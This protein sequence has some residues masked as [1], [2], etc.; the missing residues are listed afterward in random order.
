MVAQIC[1]WVHHHAGTTGVTIP[2]RKLHLLKNRL[3]VQIKFPCMILMLKVHRNILGP[4]R[5][6]SVFRTTQHSPIYAHGGD[7]VV[8]DVG[9]GG[10]N[11][12]ILCINSALPQ[13]LV[14]IRPKNFN[15][16]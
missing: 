15:K 5:C 7:S 4:L 2:L 13:E 3:T 1:V 6:S 10:T 9:Y 14:F 11:N 16:K 12:A 8:L